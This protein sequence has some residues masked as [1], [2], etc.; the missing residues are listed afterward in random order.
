MDEK[1]KKRL[2]RIF[3]DIATFTAFEEGLENDPGEMGHIHLPLVRNQL[4]QFKKTVECVEKGLPIVGSSFTNPP[5]I[6]TAMDI[7]WFF[8][9]QQIWGGAIENPHLLED[10]EACD[11]MPVPTDCCTLLRMALYYLDAGL[12]PLP[13]AYVGTVE[14]C[15]GISSVHEAY[16]NHKEWRDIPTFAPEPTYYQ[17]ERSIKYYAGEM[18]RMVDFLEKHTGTTLD[19][20]RLKEVVEESNKQYALWQEYNELRRSIPSPHSY[21]NGQSCFYMT[22]FEGCGR[23]EHTQWFNDLVADAEMRVSENRPEMPNQRIRVLWFDIQPVSFSVLGPWLEQEMGVSI[24]MDMVSYCP[25]TLIDTSTEDS[26]F[27]GLAKRSLND[28]PMIRQAR[29]VADNFLSDIVRIV[30]D[31]K[32]DCVIWPAHMGHK[33][34][35]ASISLMRETCRDLGVP[36][37]QIGMDHVDK[38]YATNDEIKDKIAHF[39]TAMGLG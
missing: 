11:K 17:D 14:P 15:D 7:R 16:I 36:F 31:F 35:A 18:K 34:G 28:G 38:R 8:I 24:V 6:F 33:D 3:E 12:L 21:V 25:Y 32:I 23:P 4:R 1:D 20:D 37:L 26:I 5:E 39:F 9:Q 10:L 19:M 30:T 29:G 22:N 27:E 2:S 13:T